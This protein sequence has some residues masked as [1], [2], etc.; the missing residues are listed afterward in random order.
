MQGLHFI[1]MQ[2]KFCHQIKFHNQINGGDQSTINWTTQIHKRV[3][4]EKTFNRHTISDEMFSV[5]AWQLKAFC[6][7][8]CGDRKFHVA[9]K[10]FWSP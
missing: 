1:T 7:Q 5:N 3:I 9:M 4:T 10:V 6:H 8:S 2:A